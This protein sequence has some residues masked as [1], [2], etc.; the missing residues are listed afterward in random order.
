MT[1]CGASRKWTVMLFDM[2]NA[3][4]PRPDGQTGLN[5]G[6]FVYNLRKDVSDWKV[7]MRTLFIIPLVLMSLVSFPSWG[8]NIKIECKNKITNKF[9][10]E[11]ADFWE[12]RC[13]KYGENILYKKDLGN[14]T[15][16]QHSI[17]KMQSC[18][19]LRDAGLL[20]WSHMQFINIPEFNGSLGVA[21]HYSMPCWQFGSHATI[22]EKTYVVR[23]N[24]MELKGEG[25]SNFYLDLNTMKAGYAKRR[26]YECVIK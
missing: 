2:L 24:L 4:T 3:L 14:C 13:I 20:D 15:H 22:Y 5:H 21:I 23:N 16:S 12:G 6:I 7:R 10:E 9:I 19:T 11:F 25:S 17:M 8:N 1:V 18:Q 26:D